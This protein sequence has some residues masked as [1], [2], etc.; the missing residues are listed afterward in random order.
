MRAVLRDLGVDD[1]S[2]RK[3]GTDVDFEKS[4]LRLEIQLFL[5]EV[6]GIDRVLVL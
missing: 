3:N 1:I 5:S 4:F 6:L 2:G